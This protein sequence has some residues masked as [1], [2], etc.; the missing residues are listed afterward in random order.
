MTNDIVPIN[1]NQSI[2]PK[3]A[4]TDEQVI[5]LW[6]HGRSRAT[7]RVYLSDIENFLGFVNKRLSKVI[8][9]D[10]QAYSDFL[11]ERELMP[12][13]RHRMLSA[14]KS[15]FGFAH[16]IGFLQFDVGRALRLPKFKDTISERILSE[17]ELQK[18]IGMEPKLRNQLILRVLYATALRISEFCHQLRWDSLIKRENGGQVTVLA[19]G[20][21]THTVL[22]LEPLWSDFMRLRRSAASDG[23]D[24]FHGRNGKPLITTQVWRI[25]KRAAERAGI[26][27]VVSPHVLRAC[28]ATH[29]IEHNCPIHIVQSTLNHSNV[30]VT[31]R[32]LRPK[33]SDSSVKYLTI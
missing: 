8:L 16:K 18:M 22:I 4:D 12:A 15:L 32:Y 6:L 7:Q 29:A 13:T 27:K 28:H 24:V 25:V 3:Q 14:V 2:I 19:K 31:S 33:E 26:S 20:G 11:V 5:A 23:A 10:L 17:S 21:K 1:N 9:R 30:S